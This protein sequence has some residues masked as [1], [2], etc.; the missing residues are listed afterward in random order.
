MPSSSSKLSVLVIGAS[1]GIGLEF[2]RQYRAAGAQVVATARDDAAIE[3]LRDLG[4][5][6]LKLDVARPVSVSSLAWQIDG[7]AF[8]IVIVN[9]GVF[10]PRL[11]TLDAP[12]EHDFNQVM[13]TNVLGPMQVVPQVL[14][15][16]APGARLVM[17]SSVMGS[18]GARGQASGWL[19][20]ASKAALNSVMKDLAFALTGRATCVSVH[21][22][23]VRTE[24]GG[25]NAQIDT[26]N[27][28]RNLRTLIDGLTPADSGSFRDHEGR[29]LP[30]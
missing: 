18:I 2:V 28:V 11:R 21:P 15:S 8:D 7:E 1:R 22:G 29:T 4:A 3:Q 5:R 12:T 10:G 9:A 24:M 25:P 27:S 23:W 14:E 26:A 19:Y 20:G 13:H 6:P 16:L 17:L 30:W